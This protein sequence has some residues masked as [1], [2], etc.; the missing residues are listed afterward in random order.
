MTV[1]FKIVYSKDEDTV[2]E[3]SIICHHTLMLLFNSVTHF[4]A[5]YVTMSH[6]VFY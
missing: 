2:S 3:C 5:Y 6:S 1:I 4:T